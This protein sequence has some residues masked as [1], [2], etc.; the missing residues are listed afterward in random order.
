ML[1]CRAIDLCITWSLILYTIILSCRTAYR[2][3]N[4]IM[5][6]EN[7]PDKNLYHCRNLLS[8]LIQHKIA[9]FAKTTTGTTTSLHT[10]MAFPLC[11]Q[12][13]HDK[14]LSEDWSDKKSTVMHQWTT[15]MRMCYVS[16]VS[17]NS[18]TKGASPNYFFQNNVI[19][20][21]S[22]NPPP[23]SKRHTSDIKQNYLSVGSPLLLTC[24]YHCVC[25]NTARWT[26]HTEFVGWS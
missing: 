12:K 2:Y 9:P 1:P 11:S 13:S 15:S 7:S 10:N 22:W 20:T 8:S 18:S 3:I 6:D 5:S 26:A 24:H 19:V 25:R 23:P 16:V 17:S 4:S 14:A 21:L